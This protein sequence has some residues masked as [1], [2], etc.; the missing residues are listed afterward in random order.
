M[1]FPYKECVSKSLC[2]QAGFCRQDNGCNSRAATLDEHMPEQSKE[3]EYR[4][5]L[6]MIQH[7]AEGSTS[8][9]SL[10]NIARIARGDYDFPI[11]QRKVGKEPCGECHLPP[12][13]VC[14][15]CGTS[16][17]AFRAAHPAEPVNEPAGKGE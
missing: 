13:E 14:D 17:A 9:N 12:D 15:I 4:Q 10:P 8:A 1:D 5:R 6:M 16:W 11:P 7:I 3:D 2:R